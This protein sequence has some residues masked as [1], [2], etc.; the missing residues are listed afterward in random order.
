MVEDDAD[1]G[2]G[3]PLEAFDEVGEAAAR[4]V[5]CFTVD[6]VFDEPVTEL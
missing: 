3:E 6:E 1:T 5:F 2:V 4:E